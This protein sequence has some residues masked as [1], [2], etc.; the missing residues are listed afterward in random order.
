MTEV[1][2]Q[3]RVLAQFLFK[4]KVLL[5]CCL[6]F[7]RT[8]RGIIREKLQQDMGVECFTEQLRCS[9]TRNADW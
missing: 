2:C 4:S 7:P 9:V 6:L 8:R 1:L 5:W 3:A